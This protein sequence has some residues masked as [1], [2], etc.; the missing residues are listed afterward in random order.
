MI[1]VLSALVV[2]LGVTLMVT[3][4]GS[5]VTQRLDNGKSNG[6]RLYLTDQ[7]IAGISAVADHRLRLDPQHRG[8]PQLDHGRLQQRLPALRQLHH[9]RQRPA[10]AGAVRARARRHDRL[11]RLLRLRAVALPARPHPDRARRGHRD[12]RFAASPRSGTTPWSRRSRSRCSRTRCSGATRSARQ[13]PARC[14]GVR[15]PMSPIRERAGRSDQRRHEPARPVPRRGPGDPLSRRARRACRR[16]RARH[17][18]SGRARRRTSSSRTPAS[19]GC[20]CRPATASS[21]R[22]RS[23]ATPRRPHGRRGSS[24]TPRSPRCG[25]VRR[26]RCCGTPSRSRCPSSAP[27]TRSTPT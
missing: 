16:L 4:L 24:E 5:V 22:R 7:A 27:P 3:P 18:R 15:R 14:R 19:P 25:P 20:W 9:R 10:V 13:R 23:P 21:R 1:G 8:R 11:L 12:R 2:V 6:V 26:G 17:G